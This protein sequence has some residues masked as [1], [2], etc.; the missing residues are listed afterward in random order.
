MTGGVSRQRR[1]GGRRFVLTQ[2]NSNALNT[3]IHMSYPPG[4]FGNAR[5][6]GFVDVLTANQ[7]PDSTDWCRLRPPA[8]RAA[9]LL[10]SLSHL[11]VHHVHSAPP[12][13]MGTESILLDERGAR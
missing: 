10:L 9:L 5:Q 1:R 3:H 2:F 11:P 7:T 4:T 6:R 12:L 8:T 13:G